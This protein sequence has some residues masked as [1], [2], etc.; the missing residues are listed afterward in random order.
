MET[1]LQWLHVSGL[2]IVL[3]I[4]SII[5]VR[6]I[7]LVLRGKLHSV[8]FGLELLAGFGI[9]YYAL[10]PAMVYFH[11]IEYSAPITRVVAFLWWIVLAYTVN[12]SLDRFVWEGKLTDDG[13]R[14]VPK[15]LTDIIS[16]LVY[17]AAIMIV[18]HYVYEE[19]ITAILASSGAVA[20]VVGLAAQPTIQEIFAGLTLNTTKALRIGDFV[21]VD[22]TYGEVWEINWRSV[23]LKSPNT[24]S[25]H[26]FPNS[27]I[28]Q[29]VIL[30]FSEPTEL[31]KYWVTFHIEYSSSPDLAI[32]AIEEEL[33]NTRYICRDPKPDF[34]ILGF[35]SLGMEMR[36]R[37]YFEG[38]DL[39]WPAQNEACMAIWSGLRRK[40]VRLST[41]RL[42]LGS[43]DEFDLNPWINEQ[44]A[45]PDKN[46]PESLAN[47]PLL[48]DM[49]TDTITELAQT[50]RRLD[51]TPPD[52]VFDER[53]AD[54]Y[55]Y[56]VVEG[57]FAG[58]RVM[59][60]GS[61]AHVITF[62]KGDLFGLESLLPSE[63][64]PHKVQAD[65][66]GVVYQL[67]ST[68]IA[69]GL[70]N[71]PEFV[72]RL[73]EHLDEEHKLIAQNLELHAQAAMKAARL[74]HH[75]ELN[76]HV[77][78][79]VEDIFA[80]PV[81]HRLLNLISPHSRE[82]DLLEAMMAACALI[83][84]SRGNI[85]DIEKEYLRKNLGAIELFRHVESSEAISL[86]EQFAA[87]LAEGRKEVLLRKLK[88][89]SDEPRLSYLV[90]N[91]AHGM[92]SLHS[93]VLPDEESALEDIASAM[94][95]TGNIDELVAQAKKN[96]RPSKLTNSE[97]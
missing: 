65:T 5:F 79:H 58:Y 76:L 77:R 29:K 72:N 13:L 28:A 61:E 27:V 37:F 53:D 91:I 64:D 14:R 54:S 93:D 1:A 26:I 62:S 15:L 3:V 81:L 46:C 83:A 89:I 70:K 52:C 96:K 39:W 48:Q 20:F 8:R 47:H 34:N 88:A 7:T 63:F 24:G 56:F 12:G 41:E 90:M 32:R 18:M 50:A 31:F 75:A 2:L 92:T 80:K 94:K 59:E 43:G 84:N 60:D 45:L 35:S 71:I 66:Y 25:L 97:A 55:I 17:A 78:E 69:D 10:P 57:N 49:A 36:L 82:K 33:K 23:A 22:G 67:D 40:G 16:L 86:F 44:T 87:Q 38:D 4:T 30:N 9:L 6:G 21:E 51:Y 95:T 73:A 11:L 68:A 42:K 74:A 85:D 19:P